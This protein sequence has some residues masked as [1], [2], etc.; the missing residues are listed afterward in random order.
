M[1]LIRCFEERLLA[2]SRR[3]Q[4]PGSMHLRIDQEAVAARRRGD[5]SVVTTYRGHGHVLARHAALIRI[6]R[7][8]ERS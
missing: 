4:M 5:D 3:G 2:L 7:R 8:K 6:G 1:R